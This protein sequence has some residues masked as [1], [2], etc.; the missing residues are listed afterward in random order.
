MQVTLNIPD[1]LA[2]Q[3]QAR[4]F[5]LETYL[6]ELMKENLSGERAQNDQRQQAVAAMLDFAERH[7]ATLGGL[8]LK[9]MVHEGHRY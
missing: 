7:G 4:G 2:A 6:R 5:V 9:S 8:G 3:A 1:D